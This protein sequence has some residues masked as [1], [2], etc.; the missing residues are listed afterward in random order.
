MSFHLATKDEKE[1]F[2]SF[3]THPLQSWEWGEF[4]EKTGISVIRL[5][6]LN[7]KQSVQITIHKIPHSPFT[8]GYIPKVTLPD[9]QMISEVKKIAKKYNCIFIQFEPNVPTDMAKDEALKALGLTPSFHPLFTKYT[10][11]LK[12]TPSEEQLLKDMHPKTR[13]NIRVAQ[14]HDVKVQETNNK[15]AFQTYWQLTEETTKRQHFF[16]HTKHYHELMWETLNKK[17]PHGLEAHLFIASYLPPEEKKRIPLASWIIFTFNNKL[18]YPYGASSNLFRNVMASNAIMWEVIKFGKEKGLKE[19]DMWGSL[20]E[21]PDTKDP[22][23]GFHRLK[24][25]Y[26]PALIE[27]LG[28]YDLVMNPLLY[29]GYKLADKLRWLFLRNK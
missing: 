16:A 9:A 7:K 12:L 3:A 14:R 27:F 11:V 8:I 23:Y 1:L 26:N 25:G 28:S 24:Q 18:Y 6:N 21:N 19:F 13:Y 2:N 10:F 20:G 22:W 5:I 29:Q 15:E 17:N 4:R